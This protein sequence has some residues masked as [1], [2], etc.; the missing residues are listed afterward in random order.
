MV[1]FLRDSCGSRRALCAPCGVVPL[2][3]PREAID[4][5][6]L[7]PVGA[8]ALRT[9]TKVLSVFFFAAI[10]STVT[11]AFA[12]DPQLRIG[13]VIVECDDVYSQHEALR[14]RAY[15]AA[16]ALHI[17][18]RPN[19]IR[20][21]LLFKEGDPY[22]PERVAETERN[23]R[24]LAFLKSATVIASEP[25]DGVVDITIRTQDTWSLAPGTDAGMKGGVGSFGMQI[26]DSN[27]AGSGQHLSLSYQ[28]NDDRSR[29]AIDY[30]N[31]SL[32]APYWQSRIW[33]ARA[34]DG[35]EQR[36]SL[37]RPF[38]SFATPWSAELSF[39]NLRQADRLFA[40]GLQTDKFN[41]MH[42]QVTVAFGRAFDVNDTLAR[43]LTFGVRTTDDV[44]SDVPLQTSGS[45]P[46]NRQFRYL[47]GRF[48]RAENRFITLDY[49]D[50]D[51]RL[52]DFDIG[53]RVSAEAAVSPAIAGAHATTE[54]ARVAASSG[55]AF[56]SRSFAVARISAESRFESGLRNTVAT[57]SIRFVRR[58]DTEHPQTFVGRIVIN[59][60]WRL[61]RDVQF[62]AD[63]E[64]GLR[65]Y[66]MH[67]FEGSRS[68]LVNAEQ[69]IYLG[70]EL[71]Q[72]ASPGVVVF[73]DA[74]NA[75]YGGLAQLLKLR[76]DV[77][78]GLRI[79]LPRTPRNVLRFDLALPL[80]PDASGRR[81]PT[82]SISSSQAF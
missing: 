53:S 17:R 7:Q 80:V 30:R 16:D 35:Y 54:F 9:A 18:T 43:R 32:F 48:E 25:H 23:L 63:G 2:W 12:A 75:T 21:F 82:L 22:V 11:S 76:S 71:G 59:S 70:R 5:E 65:G 8:M 31:P 69:R 50:S 46:D 57:G 51:M 4:S 66:H 79:G 27:L 37:A 52:Q 74:G 24:A 20:K 44:F 19:I 13:R 56:D 38:Y 61:D 58:F 28:K 26:T 1:L 49:I 67:A 45:M 33:I 29:T 39:D 55:R 14:G 3:R 34:S 62:F 68:F 73:A 78:V 40:N 72:I 42:R 47:F 41:E 15:R 81:K 64:S 77:G 36:I 6:P 10:L 60:G